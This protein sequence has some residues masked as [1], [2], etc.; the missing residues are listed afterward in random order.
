MRE[1]FFIGYFDANQGTFA[2]LFFASQWQ[3][4]PESALGIGEWEKALSVYLFSR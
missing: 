2:N 4:S 1:R 3:P